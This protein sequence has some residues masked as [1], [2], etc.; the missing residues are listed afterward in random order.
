MDNL[1]ERIINLERELAQA[2]GRP[3]KRRL[4]PTT[5]KAVVLIIIIIGVVGILTFVVIPSFHGQKKAPSPNPVPVSIQR[6]VNFPVYYPVQS[7]LPVGYTLNTS[8]F[9]VGNGAAVYAVSYNQGKKIVFAVQQKPS[10][11]DIQGFYTTHMPLHSDVN[12]PV[13]TAAIGVINQQT[14]VS[15]PTKSNAWLLITAPLNINQKHLK[16]V[17]QA[18]VK[19][20]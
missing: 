1:E 12:T 2:K 9:S 5:I 16:Q 13:G 17:V 15:L 7:K 18:I 3:S 6:K 10:A 19:P 8:S 4:A 20:N 11:V 14:V